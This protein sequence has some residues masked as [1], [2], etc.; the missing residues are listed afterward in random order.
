MK[1]LAGI[2]PDAVAAV[3]L[4]AWLLAGFELAA[5]YLK[6]LGLAG[7][8]IGRLGIAI[9]ELGD[10]PRSLALLLAMTGALWIGS[11]RLVR[12][13][14]VLLRHLPLV[15]SICA[16]SLIA[17]LLIVHLGFAGDAD[18]QKLLLFGGLT[19]P[20]LVL[21]VAVV[22]GAGVAVALLAR[23]SRSRV[24]STLYAA[25]PG[26]AAIGFYLMV[27]RRISDYG[28]DEALPLLFPR[29]WTLLVGLALPTA[30]AVGLTVL[31]RRTGT[32]RPLSTALLAVGPWIYA[33]HAIVCLGTAAPLMLLAGFAVDDGTRST[34][35]WATWILAGVFGAIWIALFAIQRRR[36]LTRRPDR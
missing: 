1:R 9:V 18:P 25:L 13:E 29:P 10:L 33:L 12:G 8:E 17:A 11:E 2:I 23:A 6:A 15:F 22:C 36:Y 5:S 7:A 19:W 30:A 14:P 20:L 31:A 3:G 35:D 34:N 24:W 4:G 26:L 27:S 32:G 28:I 16:A 21:T